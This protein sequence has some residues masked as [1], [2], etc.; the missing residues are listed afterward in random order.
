[1]FTYLFLN[2]D[3]VTIISPNIGNN[4]MNMYGNIAKNIEG[5]KNPMVTPI[6]IK[7]I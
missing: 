6:D 2:N 1:L 4:D 5:S 3:F 7:R